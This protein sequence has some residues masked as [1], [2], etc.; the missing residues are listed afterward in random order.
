MR[1]EKEDL[2]ALQQQSVSVV[3]FKL[4]LR[5]EKRQETD[6]TKSLARRLQWNVEFNTECFAFDTV[7]PSSK[8]MQYVI[9]HD[10]LFVVRD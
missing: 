3:C 4:K 6:S 1:R 5:I 9:H 2:L 8:F 10:Q 7:L